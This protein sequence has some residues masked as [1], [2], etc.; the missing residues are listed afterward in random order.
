MASRSFADRLAA[1]EA[2]EAEQEARQAPAYQAPYARPAPFGVVLT[3]LDLVLAALAD[4]RALV[5]PI[6]YGSG[7]GQPYGP[8]SYGL[9]KMGDP[10]VCA[11]GQML[12]QWLR[13]QGIAPTTV[14]EYMEW[15]AA[16]QRGYLEAVI[17]GF[18]RLLAAAELDPDTDGWGDLVTHW[19]DVLDIQHTTPAA[20]TDWL[21][22]TRATLM[23]QLAPLD[24]ARRQQLLD[25][26]IHAIECG[27]LAIRA[28]KPAQDLRQMG[29]GQLSTCFVLPAPDLDGLRHIAAGTL[30]WAT[31]RT[32]GPFAQSS[33]EALAILRGLTPQDVW[34]SEQAAWTQRDKLATVER[35]GRS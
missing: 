20:Y 31:I 11:A 2:L 16:Y 7:P 34:L 9:V 10:D 29:V 4:G 25:E 18:D 24:R 14:S 23:A 12:Q 22:Q 30:D 6:M 26:C 33:S 5:E 13:E 17:G 35:S 32:G 1:L 19:L 15:A 3:Q 28:F 8:L 21:E 27:D